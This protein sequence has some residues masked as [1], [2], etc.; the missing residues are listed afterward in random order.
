MFWL[1]T[2]IFNS[3]YV[4]VLMFRV[5]YRK[6]CK[7]RECRNF[8][9]RYSPKIFPVILKFNQYFFPIS[10]RN[11]GANI[12]NFWLT[13]LCLYYLFFNWSKNQCISCMSSLIVTLSSWKRLLHIGQSTKL[14]PDQFTFPAKENLFVVHIIPEGIARD[15]GKFY[16]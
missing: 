7:K 16:S 10:I 5:I 3:E 13:D 9:W 14:L 15:R 6:N 2:A 8:K 4:D 12:C 1:S 11:V